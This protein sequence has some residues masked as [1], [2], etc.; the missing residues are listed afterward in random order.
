MP[1]PAVRATAS[2]LASGPPALK[3]ALGRLEHALAVANGVGARPPRLPI[4][5][6]LAGSLLSDRPVA[7]VKLDPL[8]SGGT[9]RISCGSDADT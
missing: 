9:L 2:R 5:F 4:R 6:L 8:K 7:A 3:T 1:T